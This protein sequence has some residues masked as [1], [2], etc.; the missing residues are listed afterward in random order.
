M[1]LVFEEEDED[2]REATD[3]ADGGSGWELGQNSPPDQAPAPSAPSLFLTLF[4]VSVQMTTWTRSWASC[5]RTPTASDSSPALSPLPPL[6]SRGGFGCANPNWIQVN[7]PP[8]SA[9]LFKAAADVFWIISS[10][11]RMRLSF[12]GRPPRPPL[13]SL[14]TIKPWLK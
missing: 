1:Q 13:P 2:G 10:R 7:P 9:S 14:P 8:L 5:P 11:A 6:L 3:Q 12:P 4:S